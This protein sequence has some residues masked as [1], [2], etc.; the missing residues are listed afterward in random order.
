M[1]SVCR[2]NRSDP[3]GFLCRAAIEQARHEVIPTGALEQELGESVPGQMGTM[4]HA[5]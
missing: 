4:Q 3:N 1:R 2:T 5:I